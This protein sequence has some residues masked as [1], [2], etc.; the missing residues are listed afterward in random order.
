MRV[1]RIP[2]G[3]FVALHCAILFA[4][5]FAPYDPADQNREFSFAPPTKLHWRDDS[6]KLRL[7]PFV[8]GITANPSE[9]TYCEDHSTRHPVRFFLR[10][11]TNRE[12]NSSFHFFGVEEPGRLFLLGTDDYGRD[13]FSRIL[14]GGRVSVASGV[15]AMLLSLIVGVTLGA[16]AGLSGGLVDSTIMR[17]AELGLALSWFYLLLAIRAF[18]PMHIPPLQTFFLVAGVLGLTGWSRPARLIRGVVL[19]AKERGFVQSARGF[20]ASGFYVFRRHIFPQ[21]LP[22]IRTQA[23]ILIPQFIMA[24]V[25]LSFLGLGAT[26]P[27]VSWGNLLAELLQYRVLTSYWWMTAPVF[28][29]ALISSTYFALVNSLEKGVQSVAV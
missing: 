27:V 21:L 4:G 12:T 10:K 24:E 11:R 18:L 25:A 1:P 23:V 13:L 15:L 2:L 20:G 28:A 29:L 8:Y 5:F 6:G 16:I 9:Q 19:S 3:I 22:L 7:R 26:E 17:L 14:Y